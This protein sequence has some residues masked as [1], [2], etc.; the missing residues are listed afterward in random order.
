M[1]AELARKRAGESTRTDMTEEELEE[2]ASKSIE[3]DI[4]FHNGLTDTNKPSGF[5]SKV[6]SDDVKKILVGGKQEGI[7]P[8]LPDHLLPR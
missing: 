7:K 4:A 6:Q 8:K 1:G 5:V 2:F 3:K